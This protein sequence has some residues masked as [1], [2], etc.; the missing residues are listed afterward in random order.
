MFG[1]PIL[2]KWTENAALRATNRRMRKIDVLLIE[3][4]SLWGDED[5]YI[6]GRIDELR[7]ELDEARLDFVVGVQE[8]AEMRT[9]EDAA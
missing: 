3:I 2:K 9:M 5:E 7:R 8:R 6:C 1:K 4:G